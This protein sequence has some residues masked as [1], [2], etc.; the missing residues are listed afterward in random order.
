MT[1]DGGKGMPWNEWLDLVRSSLYF[2]Y[3]KRLEGIDDRYMEVMQRNGWR[4]LYGNDGPWYR[5]H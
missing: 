1:D 5:P 3:C 2:A 4:R